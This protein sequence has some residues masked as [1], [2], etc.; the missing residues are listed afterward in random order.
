[1][2]ML[3]AFYVGCCSGRKYGRHYTFCQTALLA[4]IT[5]A[6]MFYGHTKTLWV[7]LMFLIATLLDAQTKQWLGTG[8]NSKS[9]AWVLAQTRA[10]RGPIWVPVRNPIAAPTNVRVDRPS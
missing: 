2:G 9:R 10:K 7:A 5:C 3:L 1:L 4:Y 6:M 8:S